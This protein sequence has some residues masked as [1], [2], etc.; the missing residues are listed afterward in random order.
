[1]SEVNKKS[2]SYKVQKNPFLL[3]LILI[4][5]IVIVA[6]TFILSSTIQEKADEIKSTTEASTQEVE[7]TDSAPAE[8]NIIEL[9]KIK[10]HVNGIK[11]YSAE[12]TDDGVK[13]TVTFD[14]EEN[15]LDAHFAGGGSFVDVVPIFYFYVNN[16]SQI[17]CPG[18]LKFLSDGVSVEY[19]LSKLDDFANVVALTDQ[20]TVT[21]KNIF[22]LNFNVYLQHKTNDGVGRTVIGNY[23]ITC[24]EYNKNYAKTPADVSE[25]A[26]GVKAV[27]VTKADEFIWVDIYF[28]DEDAYKALNNNFEN[29]FLCFGFEKGGKKFDWKFMATEYDNI[30]MIRCKFDS[31]SMAELQKEL[32]DKN[33][34]IP[35]LFE[36]YEINIWTSN[37]DKEQ[38]LFTLN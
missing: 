13:L 10:K 15:L 28:A 12:A 37:Y 7:T 16:G 1:M 14:K 8:D 34:T 18:E 9:E 4:M 25:L 36:E 29:N 27:D 38:T 35:E 20:F 23:S 3:G 24:E 30:K 21:N 31:Y 19:T 26:E 11:E 6:V 2:F 22:A 5:V 33:I 17:G 32:D